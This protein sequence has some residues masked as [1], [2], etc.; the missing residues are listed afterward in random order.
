MVLEY[1]KLEFLENIPPWHCLTWHLGIKK[2]HLVLEFQGLEYC[3]S[4]YPSFY[5]SSMAR[6]YKWNH[7]GSYSSFLDSSTMLAVPES[8]KLEFGLQICLLILFDHSSTI[9]SCHVQR[10]HTQLLGSRLLSNIVMLKF[11]FTTYPWVY[12]FT[13]LW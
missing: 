3:V 2:C 7:P 9:V 8:S 4:L 6:V 10:I 12:T 13:I 1:S 5:N 11:T